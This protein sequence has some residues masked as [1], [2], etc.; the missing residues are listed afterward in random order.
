MTMDELLKRINYS[1]TELAD[2]CGVS[3][4][5]VCHFIKGRGISL[6]IAHAIDILA[7]V[8]PGTAYA[9][10]KAVQ[11]NRFAKAQKRLEKLGI[12]IQP[13][14]QSPDECENP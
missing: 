4:S 13:P 10:A 5:A 6:K 7:D 1:Q 3:Q 14:A 9:A 11:K 12:D 2:M 8:E